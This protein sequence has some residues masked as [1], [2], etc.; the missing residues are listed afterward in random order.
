MSILIYSCLILITTS[1]TS[2]FISPS[3]KGQFVSLGV[4]IS[5]VLILPSVF[6]VLLSGG[7]QSIVVSFEKP[8]GAVRLMMDPLSAFFV[9][10]ITIG[11][12]LAT[13]YSIGY[14]HPYIEQKK[15]VSVYF[16]CLPV[17]IASMILVVLIRNSLAFLTVWEMMSLSSFFLVIFEHEKQEVRRAGLNYLI[18]MQFCATLLIVAFAITAQ[19]SGTFDMDALSELF[20]HHDSFSTALFLLFFAGFGVKAGFL[21]LHTWLP[22]AHPAAPTPVSA[23]MSGIMIKTG[24]YGIFRIVS[25]YGPPEQRLAFTIFFLALGSGLFGILHA[26][27]Q[28]DIKKLLAYS[29]IEN[30]GI[31]GTGIGLGMIGYA[32]QNNAAAVLGFGGALLHV[33]NHFV[34][35]SALFY[36]TGAIYL[37]THS[38]NMEK[39]GG[40]IHVMPITA[41]IFLFSSMAISGLPFFNGLI[42]EFLIYLGFLHQLSSSGTWPA[43]A[44]ILGLGGLSFIGILVMLCFAKVF[45][46]AYLGNPRSSLPQIKKDP[47][48]SM[49]GPML[50][51]G[52][53]MLLIG[54]APGITLPVL[55][56]TISNLFEQEAYVIP[57]KVYFIFGMLSKLLLVFLLMI[58]ILIL[59]RQLLLRK[60]GAQVS[61][62]W[63]CGSRIPDSRLQ[64][65]GGSFI[66]FILDFIGWFVPGKTNHIKPKGFFPIQA[67]YEYK[68]DDRIDVTF[69]RPLI[70]GITWILKPFEKIQTGKTRQYLLYGLVFLVFILVF[71][72]GARQ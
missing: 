36:S 31:I 42:S 53:L 68:P 20:E 30:I 35:K 51:L 59:I 11:G 12:F 58:I 27:A 61:R 2:L 67:A 66:H 18:A 5:S 15:S 22:Q 33:W 32:F 39:L 14:I 57:Q 1:I 6:K 45:S 63:D 10:P 71:I 55:V 26:I 16:F 38:R 3:R 4:L 50:F 54:F 8:I 44:S 46:V 62:T 24:I 47:P 70:Q 64:Y 43:V 19:K 9:L 25:Y 37:R 23:L 72:I 56:H 65:T 17:L 49:M 60:W 34:F 69:V 28:N 7:A 29:S 48:W 40:L 52:F 21:P 13:L 41:S